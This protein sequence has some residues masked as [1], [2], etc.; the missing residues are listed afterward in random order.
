MFG[1]ANGSCDGCVWRN[2]AEGMNVCGN[3][4]N[5]GSWHSPDDQDAPAN[6]QQ[7][8]QADSSTNSL[9]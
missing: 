2:K 8:V 5:F 9:T 4:F 1:D 7:Q 3:C 6:I